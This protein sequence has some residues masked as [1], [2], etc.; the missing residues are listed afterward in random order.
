M[1]LSVKLWVVYSTIRN[2]FDSTRTLEKKGR[3]CRLLTVRQD[4]VDIVRHCSRENC[5]QITEKEIRTL[6]AIYREG[7]SPVIWTDTLFFTAH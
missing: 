5:F 1:S 2:R 6:H 7:H 4:F 3:K